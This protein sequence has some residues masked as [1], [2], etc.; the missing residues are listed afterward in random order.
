L[1]KL[2]TKK[3][4]RRIKNEIYILKRYLLLVTKIKIKISSH[5]NLIKAQ[6][7]WIPATVQYIVPDCTIFIYQM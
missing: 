2:R 3:A 6:R 7:G 5:W 4:S 1:E